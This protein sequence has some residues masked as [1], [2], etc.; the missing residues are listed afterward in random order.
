MMFLCRA[1]VNRLVNLTG[2]TI[3]SGDDAG[4]IK[5]CVLNRS[6]VLFIYFIIFG[7]LHTFINHLGKCSYTFKVLVMKD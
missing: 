7:V 2:S 1:A 5:V 4:C 3:A 6:Y